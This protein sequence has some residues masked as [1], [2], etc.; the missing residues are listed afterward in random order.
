MPLV[1]HYLR[2]VLLRLT[3]VAFEDILVCYD[4]SFGILVYSI[5]LRLILTD[6]SLHPDGVRSF[7][8]TSRQM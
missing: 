4:F 6:Y 2:S 7:K 8:R 1:L 3:I 5:I